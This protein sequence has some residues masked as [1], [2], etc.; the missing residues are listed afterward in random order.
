MTAERC[1]YH[2]ELVSKISAVD[3]RT[4]A[5]EKSQERIEVG[6]FGQDGRGGIAGEWNKAKGK[7]ALIGGT[8]GFAASIAVAWIKGLI[9]GKTP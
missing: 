5:I 3:E 2:D 9:N 1:P 8:V 4:K 6:L 7:I